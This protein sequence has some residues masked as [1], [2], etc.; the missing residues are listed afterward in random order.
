MIRPSL[1]MTDLLL[2]MNFGNA[3]PV[4][5]PAVDELL[6]KQAQLRLGGSD[7]PANIGQ[8]H[9]VSAFDLK[10]SIRRCESHGIADVV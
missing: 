3:V 4:L 2:S 5:P 7:P 9:A 6:G 10:P 1:G 8:P